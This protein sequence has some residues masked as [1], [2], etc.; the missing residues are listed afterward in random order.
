VFFKESPALSLK[1]SDHIFWAGFSASVK[2]VLSNLEAKKFYPSLIKKGFYMLNLTYYYNRRT[3]SR[4]L[5]VTEEPL[6]S[7]GRA[8]GGGE[9]EPQARERRWGSPAP[10]GQAAEPVLSR[11]AQ[12]KR[13]GLSL[14]LGLKGKTHGRSYGS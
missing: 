14:P 8:P 2:I 10:A 12:K 5:K 4:G 1:L 9:D 13:E 3:L 7:W 11:Q 6:S